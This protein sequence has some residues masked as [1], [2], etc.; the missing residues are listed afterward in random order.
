[1]AILQLTIAFNIT[2]IVKFQNV[3]YDIKMSL[4]MIQVAHNR[5]EF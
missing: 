4:F 2:Q 1:M 3:A 5:N